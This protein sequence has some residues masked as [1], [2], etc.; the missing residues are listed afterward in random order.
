MDD[1]DGTHGKDGT[2][3]EMVRWVDFLISVDMIMPN[4]LNCVPKYKLI[5]TL[6]IYV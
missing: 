2:T 5:I 1:T 4:F 6:L 3:L